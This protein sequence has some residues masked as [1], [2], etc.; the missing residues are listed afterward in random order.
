MTDRVDYVPFIDITRFNAS[1]RE[2]VLA[3]WAVVFDRAEFVGG[4]RVREFED[5]LAGRL[6]A[7][8]AVACAN[9]TDALI[10]GLQSLGVVRGDLVA[11]PN[12][13]FWSTYEAVV[14]IGA[15]PVLVD[16]SAADLQMDFDGFCRAFSEYRFRAAILVHLYGWCSGR[17]AEFREFCAQRGILLLEDGAQAFG[18]EADGQS[19]FAGA[20]VATLS[21]YPAKVLGGV[22]DG[23]ALLVRDQPVADR[24]RSL[25]NHGRA[26]HYRYA[27][28]GWNSRMGG[29]Q[30]AFLLRALERVDAGIKSR[31]VALDRYRSALAGCAGLT[32]HNAPAGVR[33]NGYLAV[34]CHA[35]ATGDDMASRLRTR[36]VECGRVYPETVDSQ[37]PAAAAFRAS[38]LDVS[39]EFCRR[40]FNPPLFHGITAEECEHV[41]RAMHA[42]FSEL[43]GAVNAPL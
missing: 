3:D 8:H 34:A 41:I 30:A 12:L 24:A 2:A 39:R 32:W 29:L 5:S 38:S 14:A 16:V 11:I 27:E 37:K 10:V 19:V 23:G 40:V 26:A 43:Q 31:R 9:G 18:T 4:Q 28:A 35:R 33:T 21:F 13:T 15:V 22:M 17:L 1:L 36:G 42:V 25:C 6:G 20:Q 7:A